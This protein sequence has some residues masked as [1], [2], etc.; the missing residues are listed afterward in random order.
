MESEWKLE[1]VPRDAQ[2]SEEPL[3]IPGKDLPLS[4][5]N[6]CTAGYGFH[7]KTSLSQAWEGFK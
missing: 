5:C 6:R 3:R 4:L 7:S 1:C 2:E